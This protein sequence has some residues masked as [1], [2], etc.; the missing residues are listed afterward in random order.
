M[1]VDDSS[2]ALG[3]RVMLSPAMSSICPS[4]VAETRLS[5][6]TIRLL[7]LVLSSRTTNTRSADEACSVPT[8]T[9]PDTSSTKKAPALILSDPGEVAAESDS[10]KLLRL[11]TAFGPLSRFILFA[12]M[13]KK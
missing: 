1:E 8:V 7:L 11:P 6:G 4:P 10:T 12:W 2:K 5:F 13:S 3:A 9:L